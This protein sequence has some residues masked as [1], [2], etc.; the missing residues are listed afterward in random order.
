M[1]ALLRTLMAVLL[2]CQVQWSAHAAAPGDEDEDCVPPNYPGE[3]AVLLDSWR[4]RT[5]LGPL[6]PS[7]TDP[8]AVWATETSD[9]GNSGIVRPQM[10]CVARYINL[11]PNFTSIRGG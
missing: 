8:S 1:A 2:L 10:C 5:L 9:R 3:I 4:Y 11:R 7:P 6:P